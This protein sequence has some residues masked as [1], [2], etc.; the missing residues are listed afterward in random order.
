V[1][2][3]DI[4]NLWEDVKTAEATPAVGVAIVADAVVNLE[5]DAAE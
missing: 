3:G 2:I 4:L 5:S 1:L